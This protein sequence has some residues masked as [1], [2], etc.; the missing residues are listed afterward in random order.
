[1][2]VV[3]HAL[4]V[5]ER[6]ELATLVL[7]GDADLYGLERVEDVELRDRQLAEAVEADRMAE[8]HRVEPAGAP[9]PTRVRPEL[10]APLDQQV[11][12]ALEGLGRARAGAD[13][14]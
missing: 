4:V 10:V 11:A 6:G 14:G 9:A 13:P 12:H 7:V 8:H 1:M 3:Q 2:D 5:G